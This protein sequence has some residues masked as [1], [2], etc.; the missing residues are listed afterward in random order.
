MSAL[1][2]NNG[3]SNDNASVTKISAFARID[4][5]LRFSKQAVLVIDESVEQNSA[6]SGQFLSSLSAQHNAAYIA[7]SAQFNNIQTRCRIVEQLS[8]GELFDP[9]IS[10]AVSVINLAKTSPQAITIVLDNAQ[11]LSLQLLHELSQLA[12]IAKKANLTI[13]IV[14]FGSRQAG[15][16]VANNKSLFEQK[17]ALLSAQSGQLLPTTSSLFKNDV[18]KLQIILANKWLFGALLFL[19]AIA[20]TVIA[21]LQ[22]DSFKFSPALTPDNPETVSL[23]AVLAAP[24]T[25]VLAKANKKSDD[26]NE[27]VAKTQAKQL[28]AETAN[29]ENI[30]LSLMTLTPKVAKNIPALPA[31][32]ADILSAV[33]YQDDQHQASIKA[34][35]ATVPAN[36]INTETV[37]AQVSPRITISNNYYSEQ[38]GYVIQLAAFSTA[39][40]PT[41]FLATLSTIDYHA[42]QRLY[43]DK[44]MVVITSKIY[45][46]KSAATAAI[47]TLPKPLLARKPWIKSVKQI[48]REINAFHHS[49]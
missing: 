15:T 23:N 13:N 1:V 35:S 34:I 26:M 37:V 38:T 47:Q 44:A 5:I 17:L 43:N 6:L 14:M 20:I 31:S 25:M 10:L 28:N 27:P 45:A 46:E 39:N 30:Y 7:L 8:S 18:S 19:L 48:N 9:E 21:F 11:H 41:S 33:T 2:K 32:P 29:A 36:Q 4:Y 12:M 49:Q 3:L 22:Q 16:T 42:Y 40:L 24:Q